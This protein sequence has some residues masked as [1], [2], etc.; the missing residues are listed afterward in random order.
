M[1]NMQQMLTDTSSMW[2]PNRT[3]TRDLSEDWF[4][5]ALEIHLQNSGVPNIDYLT[6]SA[7]IPVSR[8]AFNWEAAEERANWEESHGHFVE[9]S[10]VKDLLSDLHS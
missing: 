7:L 6:V 5:I 4:R 10:S 8:R 2:P 3:A 1:S 9:F